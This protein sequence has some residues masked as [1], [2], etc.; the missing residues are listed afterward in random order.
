MRV[1]F[2]VYGVPLPKARPRVVRLPNGKI[3]TFTPDRTKAWE[4]S[5]QG[6]A[7]QH[8]P[9]KLFEGALLLTLGF[10]LM[11]PKSAPKKRRY[12]D[13]RPDLDNLT[14]AVKDALNGVV[15]RDD[16]QIVAM[17]VY[18]QYGDPPRVEICVEEAD[19]VQ[20]G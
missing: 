4:E 12:P 15:W 10:H 3:Q 6:Q 17:L 14:K 13:R 1:E 16:A 9:E 18:K 11:R 7:L 19:D 2:T 8:R 20:A 5:I